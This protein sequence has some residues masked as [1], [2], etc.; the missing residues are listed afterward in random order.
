MIIDRIMSR[1]RADDTFDADAI[2][3]KLRREWGEGEPPDGQQVRKCVEM[4]DYVFENTMPIDEVEEAFSNLYNRIV[5]EI[6]K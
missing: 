1:K 4:A 6:A 5:A 3:R 2:R